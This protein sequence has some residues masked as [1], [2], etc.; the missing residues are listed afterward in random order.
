MK[1][2]KLFEAFAD[3]DEN[4][5]IE[6]ETKKK[7]TFPVWA[8]WTAVAACLML[9][10]C[11]VTLP[12]LLRT[13]TQNIGGGTET[14]SAAPQTV[15]EEKPVAPAEPAEKV[16]A[17]DDALNAAFGN[18]FPSQIADGYVLDENGIE[19]YN[20]TVLQASYY[21]RE[22]DDT[23]LIRVAP[24]GY[25]GNVEYGAVQYGDTKA[26]GTRSSCV[27]YENNGSTVMYQYG[28][29]DAAGGEC[30]LMAH[31]AKCFDSP[32]EAEDGMDGFTGS[33]VRTITVDGITYFDTGETVSVEPDDSAVVEYDGRLDGGYAEIRGYAKLDDGKRL[34]CLIDGEWILFSAE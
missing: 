9:V 6:A 10:A 31:S 17:V 2:E 11:A 32:A 4:Y 23:L 27:Y 25:F 12:R 33:G 15:T 22:L 28:K 20:G 16:T 1:D 21:N 8:K 19:I 34:A 30:Y 18:L 26:D 13:R 5:V 29:T 24:D 3:I 7:K 14:E